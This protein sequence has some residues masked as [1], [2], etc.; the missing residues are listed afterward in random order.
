MGLEVAR[1]DSGCCGMAGSFGFGRGEH[2]RVSI[3]AGERGILPAVR[4]APEDALVLADGFSCREQIA[5]GTDRH[6]LHLAEVM[7]LARDGGAIGPLPERRVVGRLPPLPR[8]A[9]LGRGT[10]ELG[11]ALALAALALRAWSRAR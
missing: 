7:K 8:R 11:L 4:A 9:R 1:P 6:G 2:Y 5:Q 3:A 10:V